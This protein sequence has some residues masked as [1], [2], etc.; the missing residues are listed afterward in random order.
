MRKLCST[1]IALI[2]LIATPHALA[3]D[4]PPFVGK[5]LL[6][7][8][9]GNA[10]AYYCDIPPTDLGTRLAICFDIPLFNMKTGAYVGTMTEALADAIPA[11]N[12]GLQATVT[13]T[14]SFTQWPGKPSMTTRVHGNAQPILGGSDSMTHLT[15]HIPSPGDNNIIAGTQRFSHAQGSARESGA[16]NLAH[17]QGQEGDEIV[18][19]LIWVIHLH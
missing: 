10:T 13:S 15:G 17:F 3:N 1:L 5:E 14:F 16:V 19:D 9:K 18:F 12:G 11:D 4:T 2:T 8:A 6:L 7:N